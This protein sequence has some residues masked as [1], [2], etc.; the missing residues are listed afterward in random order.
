MQE[1]TEAIIWNLGLSV[2]SALV[3][4]GVQIIFFAKTLWQVYIMSLF[5]DTLF[6]PR[7]IWGYDSSGKPMYEGTPVDMVAFFLGLFIGFVIYTVIFYFLFHKK[8]T[9]SHAYAK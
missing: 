8:S 9:K 2:V 1:K 4:S 3:L 6:G 5:F 7:P